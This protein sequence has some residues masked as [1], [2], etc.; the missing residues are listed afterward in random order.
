VFTP[1]AVERARQVRG[2]P[3]SSEEGNTGQPAIT[4][5]ERQDHTYDPHILVQN[6]QIWKIVLAHDSPSF[7]HRLTFEAI[8]RLFYHHTMDEL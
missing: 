7:I 4:P 6:E 8:L 5:E 3:L 1:I 2:S